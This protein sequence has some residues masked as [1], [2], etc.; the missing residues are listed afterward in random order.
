MWIG[1]VSR[2]L[3]K[4]F[5]PQVSLS[6]LLYGRNLQDFWHFLLKAPTSKPFVEWT[7]C[8]HDM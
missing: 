6:M 5:L 3:L 2:E 1:R 7:I 4:L 8:H